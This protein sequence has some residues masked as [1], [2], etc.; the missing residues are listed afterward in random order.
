MQHFYDEYD[1]LGKRAD[2]LGAIQFNGCVVE[3]MPG[4][5][6][7]RRIEARLERLAAKRKSRAK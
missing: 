6:E 7:L 4:K 2:Y 1:L 5:R 3:T